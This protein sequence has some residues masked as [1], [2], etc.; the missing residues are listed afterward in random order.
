MKKI[1]LILVLFFTLQQSFSY[2][3][4]GFGP[5]SIQATNFCIFDL[6]FEYYIIFSTYGMYLMDASPGC[7]PEY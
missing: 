6:T 1:V 2:T 4:E 3:W 5:D 7:I